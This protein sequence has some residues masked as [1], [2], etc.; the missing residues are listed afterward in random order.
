MEKMLQFFFRFV[1]NF[2]M[3]TFSA[4]LKQLRAEKGETLKEVSAALELTL[5]CYAHYEQGVREPSLS[6]LVKICDYFN[7]SADYLLG[8]VDGY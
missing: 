3:E 2:R 5:P 4:R 1:Y 8:R 6:T 7:V